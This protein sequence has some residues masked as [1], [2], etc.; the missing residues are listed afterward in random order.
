MGASGSHEIVDD[1]VYVTESGARDCKYGCI[2]SS[3]GDSGSRF[4]FNTHTIQRCNRQVVD[5]RK[6]MPK[7]HNH[8]SKQ[9]CVLSCITSAVEFNHIKSMNM[10]IIPQLPRRRKKEQMVQ[11]ALRRAFN[12]MKVKS[13]NK[14]YQ[15]IIYKP[16][17]RS[18]LFWNM[19]NNAHPCTIHDGLKSL[20]EYGICDNI[21][22]DDIFIPPSAYSYEKA[23]GK[24]YDFK[25]LI[26]D[27]DQIQCALHYGIP[28]LT[29]LSI[30]DTFDSEKVIT[31]GL[32]EEPGDKEKISNYHC[33]LIVGFDN[34]KKHFICMNCW[35]EEWGDRGYCYI[36]YT[37]M[38]CY[39]DDLWVVY[40]YISVNSLLL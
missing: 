19:Q 24:Q 39:S 28:V 27:I 12:K 25:R 31:T 29:G 4:S 18:F 6:F 23:R 30:F 2:P 34:K 38:K 40:D 3:S 37:Y 5:L 26:C 36:P 22:Y 8:E 1:Y 32:V 33:F 9:S 10:N 14:V 13:V 20:Y 35:G 11:N 7:I 16:K 21:E 17:S 15:P